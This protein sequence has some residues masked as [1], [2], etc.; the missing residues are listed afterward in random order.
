MK[1]QLENQLE[2]QLEKQMEKIIENKCENIKIQADNLI[3]EINVFGERQ[4]KQLNEQSNKKINMPDNIRKKSH[5]PTQD[6]IKEFV[7]LQK[8]LDEL[9]EY[10]KNEF[11]KLRIDIRNN[12]RG[13]KQDLILY[14]F[15]FFL[16]MLVY[17]KICIYFNNLI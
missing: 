4:I 16:F 9:H 7:K 10:Y 14:M 1:N 3:K 12:I 11:V 2:K 8:D 15:I 5:E 13:V 6:N 17:I